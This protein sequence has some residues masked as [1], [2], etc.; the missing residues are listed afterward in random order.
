MKIMS[1]RTQLDEIDLLG[2][3]ERSGFKPPLLVHVAYRERG[4]GDYTVRVRGLSEAHWTEYCPGEDPELDDMQETQVNITDKIPEVEAEVQAL[5][6][7]T[8]ELGDD[9]LKLH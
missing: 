5:L 8:P 7:D 1:A 2:I 9:F 6:A 4:H 3:A